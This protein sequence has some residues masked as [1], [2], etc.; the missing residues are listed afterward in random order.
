[1]LI[2]SLF[3]MTNQDY[4]WQS[5][6]LSQGRAQQREQCSNWRERERDEMTKGES[7]ER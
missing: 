1:M 6:Y 4:T 3:D 2:D 7:G 5:L